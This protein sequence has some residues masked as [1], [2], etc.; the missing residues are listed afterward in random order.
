MS[1]ADAL[2]ITAL[3]LRVGLVATAA[4]A[5]PGV[6]LGFLLSRWRSSWK[7]L[8]QT[9]V[10]LPMVLPPV[11]IGLLLLALLARPLLLTWWAAVV[12]SAVMSL[13]LLVLGAQQGFDAVPRRLEQVATTLGASRRRV[14][15][16]ITLPHASRG[17]LFG[18]LFAFARGLGEFGATALV[19]GDIPGRTETLALAIYGRIH[20]FEDR[21]AALLSAISVLLA[22]ATT[23]IAQLF[24]RD[25]S[26]APRA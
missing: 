22:L 16:A 25:R 17:I 14:F 9:L 12:A 11:A 15:L 2:A 23:G 18:F 26:E 10:S 8:V 20:Q 3:T 6:A 7:P 4:I 5:L 24:L 1:G 21:D 13:P 19:A